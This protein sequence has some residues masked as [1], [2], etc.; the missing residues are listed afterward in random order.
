MMGRMNVDGQI[1]YEGMVNT[2]Q[3][4]MSEE[5]WEQAIKLL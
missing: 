3:N 5:Q 4:E 2:S 1:A